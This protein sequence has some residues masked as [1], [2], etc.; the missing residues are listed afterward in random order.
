MKRNGYK[1]NAR[2]I[3]RIVQLFKEND[4]RPMSSQEVHEQL[5]LQ[6]QKRHNRPYSLNP[7]PHGLRNI[8]A[9]D[10]SFRRL[11]KQGYHSGTSNVNY[12]VALFELV[13]A[14]EEEE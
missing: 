4:N 12:K 10:K 11:K 5:L 14:G 7:T 2:Y 9:K 13:K 6:K 8:L 1:I 3:G